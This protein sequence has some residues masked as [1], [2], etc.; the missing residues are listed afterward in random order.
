MAK[1]KQV[2][3]AKALVVGLK[4]MEEIRNQDDAP[5]ACFTRTHFIGIMNYAL[6]VT[7]TNMLVRERHD[8]GI[9]LEKTRT[10]EIEVEVG[11]NGDSE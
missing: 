11:T 6:E 7:G 9:V 8:G 4:S 5:E 3:L 10:V 1:N 2:E